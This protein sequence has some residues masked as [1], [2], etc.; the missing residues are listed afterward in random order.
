MQ[1][2]KQ[3]PININKK[4]AEKKLMEKSLASK[5]LKA[6][7]A[8]LTQIIASSKARNTVNMDSPKNCLTRFIFLAPTTFRIPTSLIRLF[9]RPVAKFTKLIQAITSTRS[10]IKVKIRTYTISPPPSMA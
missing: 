2:N 8:M 5:D 4:S 9:A 6:G 3:M 7:N 1:V 10:A